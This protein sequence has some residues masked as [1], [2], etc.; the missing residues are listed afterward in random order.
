MPFTK[1]DSKMNENVRL[2]GDSIKDITQAI[3]RVESKDEIQALL[4]RIKALKLEQNASK[5]RALEAKEKVEESEVMK[6]EA[7]E[8][9][10]AYGQALE[11]D[12][13]YNN[14]S[15]EELIQKAKSN[16]ELAETMLSMIQPSANEEELRRNVK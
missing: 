2:E 9:L 13:N 11:E 10:Q 15:A 6:R 12:L 14:K 1:E 4:E 3:D 7:Q 16:E 8:R 5:K